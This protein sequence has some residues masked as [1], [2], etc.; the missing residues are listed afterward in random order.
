MSASESSAI[1][2]PEDWEFVSLP[3]RRLLDHL[4]Q[5]LSLDGWRSLSEARRRRLDSIGRAETI[6]L[7]AARA[8]LEGASPVLV[9]I[10]SSFDPP[11]DV[12]PSSVADGLAGHATL[13]LERWQRLHALERWALFRLSQR[14]NLDR[15]HQTSDAL[16]LTYGVPPSE[17][18]ASALTHVNAR[19]EAHMVG[20]GEKQP[21]Q[22]RAVARSVVTMS[23]VAFA[24]LRAGNAPKGD[25]LATSRIAGLMA[26][27]RTSELIPLC[28]PLALTE[29]AVEFEFDAAKFR[30]VVR[31]TVVAT[32][33]TGVEMEALVGASIAALTLYDMLKAL[34]RSMVIGPTELLEKSG[35]KSGDYRK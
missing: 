14:P 15:F 3:V 24:T 10:E 12:V 1:L 8:E 33:R 4:G 25:V 27:K 26:T 32:E 19:G 22:R 6:D 34:D 17:K 5:K 13:G 9:A 18:V 20:V 23:S 7:A 28:H 35:G 11:L 31:V 2:E 30:V 21:S 16:G 29:A